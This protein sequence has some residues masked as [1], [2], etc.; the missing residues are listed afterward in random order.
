MEKTQRRINHLRR[1]KTEPRKQRGT[2]AP[3]RAQMIRA[4]AKKQLQNLN[5]PMGL[6]RLTEKNVPEPSECTHVH[7]NFKLGMSMLKSDEMKRTEP[8]TQMLHG[9]YM[10]G[11][12]NKKTYFFCRFQDYTLSPYG[13]HISCWLCGFVQ[14]VQI[15]CAKHEHSRSI[16]IVKLW[17]L[18]RSL[19]P[20]FFSVNLLCK[21]SIS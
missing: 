18:L 11:Y 1:C 3:S 8:S 15:W 21:Y 6:R 17:I 5:L 10:N 14:F 9:Y 19:L 13:G 16:F 12:Q 7:K 2:K 4:S 20:L